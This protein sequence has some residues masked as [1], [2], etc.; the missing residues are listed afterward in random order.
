MVSNQGSGKPTT[1]RYSP[2]EKAAAVRMVRT[3]R[4]ELD[5]RRDPINPPDHPPEGASGI[6]RGRPPVGAPRGESPVAKGRVTPDEF[7]ELKEIMAE[8][9]R[10]QSELVRHGV[11]LVIMEHRAL[12]DL[13]PTGLDKDHPEEPA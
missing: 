2:E 1:R 7:N 10:T 8:T 5:G 13:R 6:S 3:L 12:R 4:A 11:Q 9:G